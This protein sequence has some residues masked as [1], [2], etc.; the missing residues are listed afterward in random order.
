[1]IWVFGKGGQMSIVTMSEILKDA[2]AKRYAVGCY[3][4][5]NLDM[6]RGVIEAAEEEKS[7]V[8][9]CHAEVH[10]KF[11]PLEKIA[12]ILVNEARN[13]KVPVALLLDHGK[14]FDAIVIAMHLGFNAI[15]YDGSSLNYDENVSN[16]KE[17]VK[18]AK[19]LGFD[20]EA[21]LGHVTR[22]KSAGAEGDEDDSVID[23]TSLYTNPLQARKFVEETGV[24]ALAVAFGTAHGVYLKTPKLDLERL[25]QIKTKVDVPLVMHGGSGLSAENFKNSIENGISKIN[26]YTG[27]ALHAAER[28]KE[29]LNKTDGNVFY[30]NLMVSTIDAIREDVQKTMRMFGSSRRA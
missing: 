12:P 17:I 11:T 4:A 6:I 27:M 3:N 20:V 21:E 26:Y 29:E 28:L 1:M 25:K 10:F 22:P 14:S 16:T 7:P 15:M 30:H 18:I 5:I 19:T 2:Q 24:N 13:A 23:D 9:L 8:I